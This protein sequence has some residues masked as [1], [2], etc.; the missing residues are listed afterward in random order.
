MSENE[1]LRALGNRL[2]AIATDC[3]DLRAIE[4]LREISDEIERRTTESPITDL[5]NDTQPSTS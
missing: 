1:Y 5:G 2:R 3:F 4:R